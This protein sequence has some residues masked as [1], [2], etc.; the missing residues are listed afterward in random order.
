MLVHTL[1]KFLRNVN[2]DCFT[3]RKSVTINE[4]PNG[5]EVY[6]NENH[7]TCSDGSLY[8]E[9]DRTNRGEADEENQERNRARAARRA[10]TQVRRACKMIQADSMLT[11]TYRE[12][13][14]DEERLQRDV[15]A[16]VKRLRALG[17]F[18]YVMCV[19]PQQ[20]GALHVHMA[21]QSFPAW[22]K[23]SDGIKVKSYNLI[24]SIWR[25]VVGRDNGNIDLTRPR[26]NGSHRIASYIAKYV[27]KG[28]EDAVFNAKSYWASRG[29]PKPKKTRLWFDAEIS[30]WEIVALVAGDFVSRGYID[31]AQFADSKNEFL[32]FAASKP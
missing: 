14:Q 10:K 4:F 27:S 6:I 32:W 31:I 25:R 26:R 22:M 3:R 7:E 28:L 23:N 18:E 8:I 9:V 21:C 20:R 19:E 13:M 5:V 30:T 2:S 12:N 17:P 16:F 11:L 24:R 15:K 1:D 29:I